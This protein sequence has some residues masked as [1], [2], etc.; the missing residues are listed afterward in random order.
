MEVRRVNPLHCTICSKEI[1]FSF[2]LWCKLPEHSD[3]TICFV[4]SVMSSW[5][6]NVFFAPPVIE[7][8]E[9]NEAELTEEQK[10]FKVMK[11]LPTELLHEIAAKMLEDPVLGDIKHE[12]IDKWKAYDVEKLIA[13]QQGKLITIY[14]RKHTGETI[15]TFRFS[16]ANLQN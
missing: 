2:L 13:K 16:F 7:E 9:I 6:D 14:L 1:C 3:E 15:R 8:P 10:L 5:S 11:D 4:F 12:E